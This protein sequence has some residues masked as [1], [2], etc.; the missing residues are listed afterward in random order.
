MGC[1]HDF[2]NFTR[3]W[4]VLNFPP[5]SLKTARSGSSSKDVAGRGMDDK[6]EDNRKC[7][8]EGLGRP[9]FFSQSGCLEA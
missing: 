1:N 9:F 8:D 3:V 2:S 7:L 4:T 6:R 5:T